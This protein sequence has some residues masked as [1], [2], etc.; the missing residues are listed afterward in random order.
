M[1]SQHPSRQELSESFIAQ[2]WQDTGQDVLRLLNRTDLTHRTRMELESFVLNK[3]YEISAKLT[4][5]SSPL[6]SRTTSLGPDKN[7]TI[8]TATWPL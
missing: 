6:Q 7:T 8:H 4:G 2:V 1:S 5:L 3:C